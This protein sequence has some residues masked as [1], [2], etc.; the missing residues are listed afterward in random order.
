MSRAER[1]RRRTVNCLG[2]TAC[3]LLMLSCERQQP[4]SE[5]ITGAAFTLSR[6]HGFAFGDTTNAIELPCLDGVSRTVPSRAAWDLITFVAASDCRACSE[7]LRDIAALDVSQLPAGSRLF[8]VLAKPAEESAVERGLRAFSDALVCY[9]EDER[10]WT[11]WKLG[12][13][14]VTLAVKDGHIIFATD[15]PVP[16]RDRSVVLRRIASALAQH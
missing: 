2:A 4:Q 11:S 16:L 1:I 13:T 10:L 5:P 6:P 3:Q 14:P 12:E 9:D 8:A 15:L 7:H